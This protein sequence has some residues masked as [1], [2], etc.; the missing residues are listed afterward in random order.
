VSAG[1]TPPAS[2]SPLDAVL[3]AAT[4]VVLVVVALA[5]PPRPFGDSV[6]YLLM[7]ESWAAHGSP[8]LRPGDM[9]ALRRRAALSGV[10]VNPDDALGNYFEGRDGRFYCYHFAFYPL[11]TL[12][13]RY[14]LRAFGA[15]ELKAGPLTNA[16]AFGAAIGA[17]L[18]WTPISPFARRAAAALL[19]SS[20]ALGFLLWPHP[21]VLSFAMAALALVLGSRGSRGAAILCAAIASIQNPPLVLLAVFEMA[22]PWLLRQSGPLPWPRAMVLILAAV[23][24]VASPLFFLAEFSTVNLAAYETAGA[25]AFGVGKGLGLLFDPDLGL[26][27]YAPLTVALWLAVLGMAMVHGPARR[28]EGAL[29]VALVLMMLACSAT[30]NWNHGTTGPSRYVVWL[31]PLMAYLITMGP[32]ASRLLAAPGRGCR[33]ILVIA[34]AA[35]IA[36]AAHRGGVLSPLDYLEHSRAARAVLD[37]WPALYRSP[38]E[39]FRERT[40]H[41]EVDIDGPFIYENDGRCRKALARWKHA[42]ALIARCGPLPDSVRPFFQSH[43]AK[44]EKGRWVFVDY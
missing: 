5:F 15:D 30:G 1:E 32:T 17:V 7:A 39:V 3:A 14:V 19:V 35:Q 6:E 12:P 18:L 38:E 40:A 10:A 31:F 11:L 36:V 24:V 16:I 4:L 22:R 41:T 28:L 42:D 33:L 27:R 2:R 29:A 23:A 34:V 13:A 20:P 8:A 25:H 9:D 37:R 26:V 43:P 44:D 21:E